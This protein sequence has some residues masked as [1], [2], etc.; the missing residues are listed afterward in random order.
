MRG[1]ELTADDMDKFGAR[2]FRIKMLE[3]EE[4]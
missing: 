3:W 1:K 4:L 2:L